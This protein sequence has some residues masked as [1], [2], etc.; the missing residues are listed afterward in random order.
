MHFDKL[1]KK[2]DLQIKLFTFEKKATKSPR[3][4]NPQNSYY[5]YFMFSEI[6]RFGVLCQRHPFGSGRKMNFH[7]EVAL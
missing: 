7:S 3:H 5:M 2:D 6:W 1:S 4:K